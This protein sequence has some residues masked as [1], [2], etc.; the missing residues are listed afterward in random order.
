MEKNFAVPDRKKVS[1]KPEEEKKAKEVIKKPEKK[2]FSGIRAQTIE[3]ALNGMP[4]FAFV[5]NAVDELNETYDNHGVQARIDLGKLV[6]MFEPTKEE[7]QSNTDVM[8]DLAN[9]WKDDPEKKIED[10]RKQEKFFLQIM[11]KEPLFKE[12]I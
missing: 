5:I 2:I 1:K 6:S 10:W 11:G 12:R 7:I 8:Q 3:F 9:M 4:E